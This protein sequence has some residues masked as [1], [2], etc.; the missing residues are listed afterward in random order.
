MSS[1][2]VLVSLKKHFKAFQS[3]SEGFSG[4]L[5]GCTEFLVSSMEFKE[6][7]EVFQGVP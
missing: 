4:V 1:M 3:V 5:G 6:I 7:S 2:R